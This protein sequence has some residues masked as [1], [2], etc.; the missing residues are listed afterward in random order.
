METADFVAHFSRTYPDLVRARVLVALSGGRDS[1]ALLHL[2]AEPKLELQLD[3]VHVHHRLRGADADAD[4]EFCRKRCRELGIRFELIELAVDNLKP[5]TGEAAWRRR[6]YRALLDHA[7]RRDVAAV[8]TAH[9]RDDV[10]EG[11]LVQVFRGAGPRAMSG[12]AAD[13]DGRIIRPLLPWGRAEID[14]WLASRRLS[15]REDASNR[16]IHRLRNRVRHVVLPELEAFLPGLRRHLVSLAGALADGE[17]FMAAELARR[18]RFIDP[19]APDGGIELSALGALPDALRVRWLHGQMALL[20]VS[21]VSRRQAELFGELL[22]CGR[23]RAVTMDGRWR[24]RAARGRL[25]AEPPHLPVGT[26][27]ELSSDSDTGFG[28]PGWR[29]RLRDD[30]APAGEARW[31]WSP[32]RR[33]SKLTLRPATDND[34]LPDD[35]GGRRPVRGILAGAL[36]RHLRT[37]W[38]V[39]CED[40]MIHWIPGVWRHPESPVQSDRIVEVIRQ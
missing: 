24:L 3:A 10:A 12:I 17:A 5:V 28:V 4:A 27:A 2:L 13:T 34:E 36:P 29:V 32:A 6:R 33:E 35:A 37:A 20:G 23:P 40:D 31:S 22:M 25:W 1:V 19:W 38:P 16:D 26:H 18:V 15:W 9:H 11:V 30:G 7:V 21:H 39:F 14:A 8:A